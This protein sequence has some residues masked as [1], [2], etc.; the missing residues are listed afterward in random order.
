[1]P[2]NLKCS[3]LSFSILVKCKLNS[4]YVPQGVD[5]VVI[6]SISDWFLLGL[7]SSFLNIIGGRK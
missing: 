1:M 2:F 3:C 6:G 4:P 7:H 5:H